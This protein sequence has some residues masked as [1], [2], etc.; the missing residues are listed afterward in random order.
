VNSP[1][2]NW[3]EISRKNLEHNVRLFKGLIGRERALLVVVKS[4]AY[5]HGIVDVARIAM[6]SGAQWLGV[7][8]A[9]EGLL[10]RDAGFSCPI[11]VMGYVPLA[12]LKK[13]VSHDLSLA[14]S[15][16][17]TLERLGEISQSES[18]S[19]RVHLKLETGLNRL[20]LVRREL[21]LVEGLLARYERLVVEGLFTHYANIEDTL[22]HDFARS[23][24]K[25][26]Q[27]MCRPFLGKGKIVRHTACTAAVL[28]FEKTYFEMVRVGIGTYGMWP[29]K[30]T[31]ITALETRSDRLELK[32]VLTWKSRIASI[33]K[34]KPGDTVGY[35]RSYRVTRPAR[36]AVIPTGYAD[37]Y[38][39]KLSS[40][41]YVLIQGKEAPVVGR[42]CMNMFMVDITHIPRAKLEDEAI[43]LGADNGRSIS[44]ETIAELTGTIN[45][46]VTTRINP[47][48]PRLVL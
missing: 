32:P 3:V 23:Q 4:N 1:Y 34:V 9:D 17:E 5:G 27:A 18:L 19:P 38:D 35:G 30:E 26:F 16:I 46:E 45:Y 44:A 47:G 8:S 48:L 29:S 7:Y 24:L 11:L 21:P 6:E 39:R 14:V 40:H 37:G 15:S 25:S 31:L 36:I 12:L 22:R 28:L 2:L 43:L 13:A 42:I 10:L 41:G 33:K 20:G